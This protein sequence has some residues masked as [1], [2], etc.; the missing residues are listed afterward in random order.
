[1]THLRKMMLEELQRRNYAETAIDCYIRAVED[2][3]STLL[4]KR[5]RRARKRRTSVPRHRPTN[6]NMARSYNR[7]V[8]GGRLC[9]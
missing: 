5:L 6:R 4:S 3:S 2:F 1:V 9:D 8:A 7:A